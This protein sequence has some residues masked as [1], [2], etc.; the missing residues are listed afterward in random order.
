MQTKN[1]SK[2]Q[3]D[4]IMNLLG[5][6]M[7]RN[8]AL[9]DSAP[10]VALVTVAKATTA[11]S[12]PKPTAQA[13]ARYTPNTGMRLNARDHE[14]INKIIAQGM[15]HGERLTMSNAIRLALFA[16][17][18]GKMSQSDIRGLRAHDGRSRLV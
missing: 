7:D 11:P 16:Y 6:A 4:S 18:E 8:T 12:R 3:A 15:K 2:T 13:V 9:I 14:K 1:S 5:K 17:D 10:T